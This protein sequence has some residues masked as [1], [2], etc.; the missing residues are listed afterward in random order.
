MLDNAEGTLNVEKLCASVAE[1][2]VGCCLRP[3]VDW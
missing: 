2:R 3:K 1:F